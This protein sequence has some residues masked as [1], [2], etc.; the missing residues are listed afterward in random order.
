MTIF[1]I[2]FVGMLV[3]IFS[4]GVLYYN[5]F[6]SLRNMVEEA[7]SSI[8]VQ[9]KRRYDLIPNLVETVKG[10]AKHEQSTLENVVKLRNLAQ[11]SENITDKIKNENMLTSALRSVFAIAES[12]PDLKANENFLSLQS[13]LNDIENNIQSARRYYNAVVKEYNTLCESFPSVF[14]ARMFHFGR[15]EFFTIDEDEKKNVKVSF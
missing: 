6:V 12:Y 5:K 7:F 15:K 3:I 10:Y 2:I 13:S 4:I 11:S 8:D 9:L 14:I 1:S